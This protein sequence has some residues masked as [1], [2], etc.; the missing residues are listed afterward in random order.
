MLAEGVLG[1]M[2]IAVPEL[3]S[4]ASG[5][6]LLRKSCETMLKSNGFGDLV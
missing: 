2:E 1:G 5:Q 3:Y 4:A 6:N